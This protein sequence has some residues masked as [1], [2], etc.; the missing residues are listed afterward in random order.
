MNNKLAYDLP[1]RI[2]HW[3]FALL[4]AF[5][6][7]IAKVIDDDSTLYAYHMLSGILM[8]LLVILRVFWGFVGTKYARFSSFMLH[9]KDLIGYLTSLLTGK[10]KRYMSHNPASSYAAIFM[11]LA[12]LGLVATGVLMSKRV[13]KD[14][15][16]EVHEL[17]ANGFLVVVLFHIA[18]VLFHQYKHRD[19]IG[20]SIISGKK[21]SIDGEAEIKSARPLIGLLFIAIIISSASYILSS[22]NTDTQ[23]LTLPIIELQLGED[24][25]GEGSH[26]VYA[27][28]HDEEYDDD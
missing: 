8:S 15:F 19:N 3:C 26:D 24:D 25:H 23:T 11:F 28:D 14:V 20:L 1:T 5:S 16:E 12:S 18:G 27:E 22:Y 4:F 13:Y 21:K 10:T 6:F 17:A 7:F 2:F 9:L